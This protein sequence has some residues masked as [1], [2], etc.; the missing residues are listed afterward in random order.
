MC[1]VMCVVG[2]SVGCEQWPLHHNCRTERAASHFSLLEQGKDTE[3]REERKREGELVSFLSS[4]SR[5]GWQRDLAVVLQC[6]RQRHGKQ[7]LS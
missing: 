7:S 3:R 4:S 2:D 5:D 1:G 6:G